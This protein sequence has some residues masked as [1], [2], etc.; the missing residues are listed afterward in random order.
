M[1]PVRNMINEDDISMDLKMGPKCFPEIRDL[2]EGRRMSSAENFNDICDFINRRLD[3]ADFR[4]VSLLRTVYEWPH[5]LD[6]DC[7]DQGTPGDP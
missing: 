3:C 1:G 2:A 4:M 6:R 5:L 7:R